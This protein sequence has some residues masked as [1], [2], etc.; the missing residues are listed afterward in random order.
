VSWARQA[1]YLAEAA[2]RVETSPL[3]DMLVQF[4]VEDEPRLSGWQ[5]GLFT[6]GGVVKPSFNSFRLPIAEATRRGR[7]TTIWGQVR[8]GSGRRQYVLQRQS[9]GRW[10]PVG[11]PAL[12]DGRGSYRRVVY[13]SVGSRYRILWLPSNTASRAITVR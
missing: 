5:S 8:P 12:T 1:Q 2:L 7:R 10:L 9:A 3:V 13:A 6:A 11:R 4:M